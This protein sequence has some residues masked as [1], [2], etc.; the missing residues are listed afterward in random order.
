MIEAE[1]LSVLRTRTSVKWTMFPPEV[2]PLWVAEMDY[3]LAAPVAGAMIERIAASDVGY[4]YS[5]LTLGTA[6]S[7]FATDAWGWTPDPASVRMATDV[8]VT[9]VEALR[10]VLQPGDPVVITPPVYAPFFELIPEAGGR[11][12]EV[13]LLDDGVSWALDLPGLE[14]AFAA[15][16][17]AFL[18]CNPHNPLGLVHS[19]ASLAAVAEL[20]ERYGV[21]VVSDEIHGPLV[22][23]GVEFTPY[24]S[25]SDAA[26]DHGITVTSASKAFNLAGAK[27]AFMVASSPR[28]LALLDAMPEEVN[29]R[30]SILGLHA[31]IAAFQ[32]GREWLDEVLSALVASSGRLS[33][34]LA[35]ELPGVTFRPPRASYLAWLDFRALGWGD[36]PAAEAMSLGVALNAGP[37]F[38][39]PGR[40]FARLNF[41]CSPEVLDEAIARLAA[42]RE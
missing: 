14:A 11:V 21:I 25:V 15:G 9:I 41:A 34:L 32:H 6:F 31:S 36:D 1:P 20:A 8:S 16:A 39:S 19:R 40:G 38:G 42:G 26:R 2:L 7:S 4:A 37:T 23:P 30:T 18:L 35:S 17:R 10:Q 27:C 28:T 12:V 5:P 22:H 3:P 29:Y 33:T 24:L 13:P